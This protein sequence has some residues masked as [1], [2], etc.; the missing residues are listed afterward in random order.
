HAVTTVA[1]AS[2][3]DFGSVP[4]HCE[5]RHR[6]DSVKSFLNGIASCRYRHIR[7]Q[8]RGVGRIVGQEG[9][10]VFLGG[11]RRPI[12]IGLADRVFTLS[13]HVGRRRRLTT[14]DYEQG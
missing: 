1:A 12:G 10:P 2:G 3:L 4:R 13:P 5:I 9:I 6:S 14:S 7:R 8:Y 11:G